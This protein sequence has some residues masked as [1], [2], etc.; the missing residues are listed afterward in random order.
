MY[1][2]SRILQNLGI[3]LG[4]WICAAIVVAMPR[5]GWNTLGVSADRMPA[6]K[7]IADQPG[8]TVLDITV[9]GVDI[10]YLTKDGTTYQKVSLPY[11]GTT[12][13]VGRPALPLIT[14]L[15][16]IPDHGTVTVRVLNVQTTTISDANIFPFLKPPLRDGSDVTPEFVLDKDIYQGRKPFPAEWATAASPIIWRDLRLAPV[17][18]YPVR[19]NPETKE[20][21][22]ATSMRVEVVTEGSGGVSVKERHASKVSARFARMYQDRVVNWG[23]HS[24]GLDLASEGSL[25][26]ITHPSL[27]NSMLPFAEWKHQKGFQTSMVPLDEIGA[28]PT[29]QQIKDYIYDAYTTWATPP[30]YVILVGDYNLVP[31]WNGV[32]GSKTD[33]IYSTLEGNDYIADVVVGRFPVNSPEECDILVSKL[34]DY[35]RDPYIMENGWYDA[36]MVFNSSDGVD[37]ENGLKVRQILLDADF[38]IV[39]HFQE[40]MS[41]Q[42]QNLIDALNDGRSWVF[43]IGHGNSTAWGSTTPYFTNA[44]INAL[45]NGRKLPVIISIA[46]ANAD[47]DY[48]GEDCFAETWMTTAADRGASNILAFTENCAFYY[49]DTLGLGIMR[50]HFELGTPF[51]GDNVDYGRLYMFQS[52]PE[53]PGGITERTMQQAMLVGDPTQLVWS[54]NPGIMAVSHPAEIHTGQNVIPVTVTKNGQPVENA[55]VCAMMESG[56]VYE[57]GATDGTGIVVLNVEPRD[58]GN[59]TLTVTSENAMPYETN[60]T[61]TPVSGPYVVYQ[62]HLIDDSEGNNDGLLDLGETADLSLTL[63]NLG[64]EPASEV[65][66]VLRLSNSHVTLV[67]SVESFGTIPA[68]QSVTVQDGYRLYAGNQVSDGEEIGIEVIAN[69]VGGLSWNSDFS[70]SAHAPEMII[71]DVTIDDHGSNGRLDPGESA[72]VIITAQN[73]GSSLAPEVVATLISGNPLVTVQSGAQQLGNIQPMNSIQMVFAVTA[74]SNIPPGVLVTFSLVLN[75]SSGYA[76]ELP[77][78]ESIGLKSAYLWD[79][80]LTPISGDT[81]ASI[82]TGLGLTFDRGSILPS[83]L[84]QYASVWVFLGMWNHN[85]ILTGTEGAALADYLDGGGALYMEGGDTWAYDS[86]TIVHPYFHIDGIS[87]GWSDLSTLEGVSGTMADRMSFGYAGESCFVDRIAAY[88]DAQLI[89]NNA[90]PFY[91]TAVAFDEGSYYTIGA[92]FELGGLVDGVSASTKA[93]LV[94]QYLSFFHIIGGED[95]L[96]P[97][98]THDPLPNQSEVQGPSRV[99]ATITD[100][101]GVAEAHVNYSINGQDF[102]SI[103]M[104]SLGDD[105]FVAEIPEQ[106]AG[107]Q[108]D[109]SIEATDASPANNTGSTPLYTFLVLPSNSEVELLVSDFEE[110][111]GQLEVSLG[112]DWQWGVPTSGPRSANS[113]SKLWG[114][115]LS[116]NYSPNANATLDTPPVDLRNVVS[117]ILSIW[118]W[119]SFESNDNH[120]WDGGNVKVSVDG[121]PFQVLNPVGGYDGVLDNP[122]NPLHGEAVFG[123]NGNQWHRR[124]FDLT[125]VEGHIVIVRFQIA[126]DGS[127]QAPGWYID[128]IAIQGYSFGPAPAIDDLSIRI[129]NNDVHLRWSPSTGAYEYHIYRSG[130]PNF[131][132]TPDSYLATTELPN[133]QDQGVLLQGSS[134]FYKVV[135]ISEYGVHGP[136][137]QTYPH[138]DNPGRR[139]P[140]SPEDSQ[141]VTSNILR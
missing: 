102:T 5:A 45:T 55:M 98:I 24:G 86:Q 134:F 115:N 43:Y 79:P 128:D 84:Q 139:Q 35:E 81:V 67:D 110:D 58:P 119:Y 41:N 30:E 94:E 10:S 121:G 125:A 65:S 122:V 44:T 105:I 100:P 4:L 46:C 37:P 109:Y 6:R 77:F 47:L 80:D 69:V 130:E 103:A 95:V 40:P 13:E 91:G 22:I 28:Y 21:V 56:D 1:R 2:P 39:D 48:V 62:S 99:Q 123:I 136:T 108:I 9:P 97:T 135:A 59:L 34:V 18:I 32:N 70:I 93:E 29:A 19:W 132:L 112:S 15:V 107:S 111:N 12:H 118:Q 20:L 3:M 72:N 138:H 101:S 124:V 82:L 76:A 71:S 61:V 137:W 53:G 16:A 85:H 14:E 120:I 36:G 117:P 25:L 11:G 57:V 133:Y 49:T 140:T 114:T 26:I 42:V 88:P 78:T 116:G 7:V 141:R 64:N 27:Y 104:S 83:Q 17:I 63:E 60:V 52:F 73:T 96:P 31:W 126:S 87:D 38:S 75:A 8:R 66:A 113:G 89:F 127:N 131:D 51:F 54:E 68:G 50:S 74:S 92:S 33:H 23:S 90:N 129:V 106:P